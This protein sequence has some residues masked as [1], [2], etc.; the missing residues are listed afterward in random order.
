M[1]KIRKIYFLFILI[2]SYSFSQKNIAS[3]KEGEF[4]KY[5]ISYGILNAGFATLEVENVIEK[6]DT[7]FHVTGK[8]WT[9]GMVNFVF[10]VTDNYQSCAK[11]S[12]VNAG[13]NF[14]SDPSRLTRGNGDAGIRF[15]HRDKLRMPR[16]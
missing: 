16:L 9:T 13:N 7:L 15:R 6:K 5:R 10:P 1:F 12:G 2:S 4:L 11:L 8:G 14:W 3:F